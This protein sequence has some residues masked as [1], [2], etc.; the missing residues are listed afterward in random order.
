MQY[1]PE[2]YTSIVTYKFET[3]EE[4]SNLIY[5][6]VSYSD[7]WARLLS[8]ALI[9]QEVIETKRMDGIRECGDE[10]NRSLGNDRHR[11]TLSRKAGI[12]TQI[13]GDSPGEL[14]KCSPIS[15]FKCMLCEMSRLPLKA[16]IEAI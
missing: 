5:E 8:G 16:L 4:R 11:Y 13:C 7:V 2:I 1:S 9:I 3:W 6:C 14:E 12:F 15:P 10:V